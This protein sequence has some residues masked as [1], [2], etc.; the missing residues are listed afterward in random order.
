MF[1]VRD[2]TLM[3]VSEQVSGDAGYSWGRYSYSYK[4]TAG[5]GPV[6]GAGKYLA[7]SRKGA[8]GCWRYD[9]VLW[10]SDT[11]WPGAES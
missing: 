4:P 10:N 5:G 11:P 6:T 2:L 3:D 7:V 1:S 9:G 8:D